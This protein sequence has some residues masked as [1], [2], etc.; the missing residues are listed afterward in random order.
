[1]FKDNATLN[2]MATLLLVGVMVGCGALFIPAAVPAA[3]AIGANIAPPAGTQPANPPTPQPTA[4]PLVGPEGV[5]VVVFQ[6]IGVVALVNPA[7]G[8]A[9][10]SQPPT[11]FDGGG[12]LTPLADGQVVEIVGLARTTAQRLVVVKEGDSFSFVPLMRD[13]Q[14]VFWVAGGRPVIT[15]GEFDARLPAGE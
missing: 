1:M 6:A 14:V 11:S 13:G 3:P 12:D 8:L 10:Y 9:H 5:R 2:L 4:E 7:V 15:M